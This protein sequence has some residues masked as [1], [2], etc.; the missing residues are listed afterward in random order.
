MNS[1]YTGLIL[2]TAQY[3]NPP[4]SKEIDLETVR[5]DASKAKRTMSYFN[6]YHVT[7][8]DEKPTM[9]GIHMTPRKLS[10]KKWAP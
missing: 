10:Y 3:V 8:T 9:A 4:K 2:G 5:F 7:P 1:I 6:N